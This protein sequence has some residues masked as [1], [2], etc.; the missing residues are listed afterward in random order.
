MGHRQIRGVLAVVLLAALGAGCGGP[1]LSRD[2]QVRLLEAKNR[3][4]ADKT[5]ALERQVA[6]LTASGARPAPLP[7][8]PEDPFRV[9]AVRFN[10]YT[11]ALYT[12]GKPEKSRLKVLLEPLDAEG[13]VVKRAGG[14]QLETFEPQ[15]PDQPPKPF[16]AWQFAPPELAQAWL[17][18][19][20]VRGYVLRLP[21]PE[22]RLPATAT[23]LMRAK[24]TTLAGEVLTAETTVDISKEPPSPKG[25]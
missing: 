24:F 19:L 4:L 11:A 9:V 16:H 10:P 7:R 2:E 15:A 13:D 12:Q 14:L 5:A 20:G 18:M 22:G 17:D 23:L 6:A 25:S 21:W 1:S 3:D 8:P